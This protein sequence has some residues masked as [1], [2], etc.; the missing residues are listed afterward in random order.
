M[1][2]STSAQWFARA[3]TRIPGGVNS[4]VRS[5]KHVGATPVYFA[6]A[7][8]AHLVDVDGNRYVDFCLSF[9][10]HLLG[11][12]HPRVVA[13]LKAQAERATSYGACHADEVR[14][15]ERILAAYPFLQKVRLVNS[16]TEATMTLVRLAR[17]C[18]GRTKVIQFEG[19]YHG[20][21]DA[22]LARA[23]SGVA[24]LTES[25][26][27]GVPSSVVADTLIARFDDLASFDA[28]FAQH[29]DDVAAVIVEP[30]P[31][32]YGLWNPGRERLA[33]I[34]ATARKH[35][36]LTIFDEVITGF[37]LGATGAC[38]VFD[39]Q[40]DLVALGKIVGGGLPLAAVAGRGEIL[41][42][43]APT[44]SVYQAGTLSGNPMAVAAGLAVLEATSADPPYA[45][46]ERASAVFVEA[47]QAILPPPCT[48]HHLGSLFWIDF[49]QGG[50][51]FPP[52]VDAVSRERYAE[53][54]IRALDAGVYFSPSPYEVGF[55]STAHTP[56]ILADVVARLARALHR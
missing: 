29:P 26:S 28:H 34:V 1:N 38:G 24:A 35:G 9:G 12:S 2:R 22:F 32:N 33:H 36:A 14:L 21:A 37:R 45:R 41:D 56:E 25:S 11:H 55:V 6:R 20:H 39:L 51:A 27:R 3:R 40:P 19:C 10:P 43:L 30:V 53:F 49:S 4:P 50:T 54:F 44:G 17:G 48:V 15:A 23:G 18:T 42:M 47:L 8:G 46:L 7:E 16:G 5:F 13:A 31:A 52:P